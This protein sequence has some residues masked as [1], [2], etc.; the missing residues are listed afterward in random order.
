MT[1]PRKPTAI[2]RS[3]VRIS[4]RW[5]EAI[6][7][8]PNVVKVYSPNAT[9]D[10]VKAAA[11]GASIFIYLGHGYGFPSPYKPITT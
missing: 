2:T 8:T 10:A 3:K 4:S 11:Q 7:Y 5:L 1:K 9:W 6:K